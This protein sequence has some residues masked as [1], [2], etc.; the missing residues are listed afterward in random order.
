MIVSISCNYESLEPSGSFSKARNHL[1][2]IYASMVLKLGNMISPDFVGY[3]L[4]I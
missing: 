2:T 3:P 1:S 4:V